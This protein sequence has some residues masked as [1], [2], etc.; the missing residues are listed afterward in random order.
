[1]KSTSN[2]FCLI[3]AMIWSKFLSYPNFAMSPRRFTTIRKNAF[4]FKFVSCI[5]IGLYKLGGKSFINN[6]RRLVFPVP[7]C[8]T[9]NAN[10]PE[11]RKYFP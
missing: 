1:M 8:P 11:S 5:K 3:R 9:I 7:V 2:S 10:W 6:L 4:G